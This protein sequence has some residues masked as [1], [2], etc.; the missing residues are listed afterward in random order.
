MRSLIRSRAH[1]AGRHFP[2]LGELLDQPAGGAGVE[3][4]Y[5]FQRR[6][7][8]HQVGQLAAGKCRLAQIC[9]SVSSA[10]TA[11]QAR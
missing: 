8:E 9:G 11:S 1:L 4:H 7:A 3:D 5:L 2:L 10:V 6:D